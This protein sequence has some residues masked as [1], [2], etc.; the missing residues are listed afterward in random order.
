MNSV[1]A[2][3]PE[4]S[5]TTRVFTK[6]KFV[7]S[8]E[9]GALISFVSQNPKTNRICGV[10]QDSPYPK[11]VCI[12]DK[13]LAGQIFSNVLYDCTLIPMA[14]KSDGSF[15]GYV[16]VAAEP[17]Q[18]KAQVITK[19]DKNRT[20]QVEVRFGNKVILFDPYTGKK[21]SVRNLTE[22]LAVLEKRMDV[23]NLLQVIEDFKNASNEILAL[24]EADRFT[25]NRK[26]K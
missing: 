13:L 3:T 17:T 10:R 22:C 8:E 4:Q 24:M 15:S 6:L 7:R 18:F 21:P 20:Y 11:K 14:T 9:T 1:T 23:V 26:R 19:Y 25:K 5:K 12:I 16:V 2:K